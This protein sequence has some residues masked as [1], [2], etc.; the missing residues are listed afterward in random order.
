MGAITDPN[1]VLMTAILSMDIYERDP[2]YGS[3]VIQSKLPSGV[4]GSATLIESSYNRGTEFGATAWSWK[5]QAIIAYEGTISSGILTSAWNGYG[6]GAG[7]P[8]GPDAT[9]AVDFYQAVANDVDPSAYNNYQSANIVLTGHSLGG[10]L[11]GY[12]GAIYGQQGVLFDSMPF[13][14]AAQSAYI[15]SIGIVEDEGQTYTDTILRSEIYG[16]V[17]PYPNNAS[18]L[19]GY[20]VTGN[21]LGFGNAIDPHGQATAINLHSSALLVAL[22][23]ARDNGKSDW[24]SIGTPLL[25][26]LFGNQATR[27]TAALGLGTDKSVLLAEIAYSALSQV[28]PGGAL[29]FGSTALSSLFS[30][31]DTLG[32]LVS[33]GQ[34]TG[35]MAIG[36]ANSTVDNALAEIAVQYAGDQAWTAGQNGGSDGQA[37]GSGAFSVSDSALSINL[38]PPNWVSTFKAEPASSTTPNI[39]G[40]GDLV[41]SLFTSIADPLD[42]SDPVRAWIQ[43]IVNGNAAF[44]TR[45]DEITLVE[46]SLGAG[47][48]SGDISGKSATKANDGNAGGALLIG[49]S[50]QGSIEGSAQGNDI[51]IDGKTV[52]TGSGNDII[53]AGSGQVQLN[54]NGGN[55]IIYAGASSLSASITYTLNNDALM[56]VNMPSS[57]AVGANVTGA[58][59]GADLIIGNADGGDTFNFTNANHAAFT[60]AWGG[61][62]ADTFN[63]NVLPPTVATGSVVQY[64]DVPESV[65]D[66]IG[67][68]MSGVTAQNIGDLNLQ[69]LETYVDKTYS[70]ASAQSVVVLLNPS[71]GDNIAYSGANNSFSDISNGT[72]DFWNPVLQRNTEQW[73]QNN[74][75]IAVGPGSLT[76]P[77]PFITSID[78]NNFLNSGAGGSGSGGGGSGSGGSSG[79]PSVATFLADQASL[80]F[81]GEPISITDTAAAVSA[82]F[83]TLS[84]DSNVTSITLTDSGVPTLTLT[85]SQVAKDTTA[86]GEITNTSYAISVVDSAAD[87]AE[88]FDALNANTQVTSIALTDS[89]QSTLSLDAEQA[90][91]DTHALAALGAANFTIAVTDSAADVSQTLDALNADAEVSSIT[92]IDSGTPTL[93]LS[94][95][96]A[97]GDTTALAEITN[98]SYAVQI[99][100]T[101][102]NVLASASAIAAAAA[103]SSVI[104]SDT[105]ANVLA[106]AAALAAMPLV[107]AIDIVDTAANVLDNLAA[108]KATPLVSSIEVVDTAANMLASEGALAAAGIG[109]AIVLDSAANVSAVFDGLNADSS[110][111]AIALT[112]SGTPT[113]TLTVAQALNATTALGEIENPNYQ[114]AIVDTAANISANLDTLQNDAQIVSIT[115]SDASSPT[116]TLI[117]A[118]L[119]DDTTA[120]GEITNSNVTVAIVDTGANVAA[121]FDLLNAA[122]FVSSIALSDSGTPTL[123]LT[124]AQAVGDTAALQKIANSNYAVDVVDTAANVSAAFAELATDGNLASITLTDTQPVVDLTTAEALQAGAALAKV[125]NAGVQIA[126]YDTLANDLA[127]KTALAADPSVVS[128]AVVD[129]AANMLAGAQQ[130]AADAE[131][132]P[133]YVADSAANVSVN[134]NTL[135]SLRDLAGVILTDSGTPTL[136]LT[137]AQFLDDGA[138]LRKIENQSHAIDIVDTAANVSAAIDTI[139][140]FSAITSIT[141]T[142]AGTPTLALNA[143]QA[144]AGTAALSSVK[145]QSYAIVVSDSAVSVAEEA[146]ALA[147]NSHIT[148]IDV[149]DDAANVSANIDALNSL[150]ALQEISVTD[151]ASAPLTLTVAQTLDDGAALA[152][153]AGSYIIAVTDTAEAVLGSINALDA[154]PA[155][156]SLNIVDNASDVVA[157][158]VALAALSNLGTVT[159][160]DTAAAVGADASAIASDSKIT[161]VN[162]TDT[163]ANVLAN[164]TALQSLTNL[165]TV[166]VLDTTADISAN[167]GALLSDDW[168]TSIVPT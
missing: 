57:I 134:F 73:I 84:D 147:A 42:L 159:I 35:L 13:A 86:L 2:A 62:G 64:G 75:T 166:T 36:G 113:L 17:A 78:I 48:D 126:V 164:A 122:S 119:V 67:L 100:D 43:N 121:D 80:D 28:P 4:L 149:T 46:A 132:G 118:Q 101:A 79:D 140:S 22:L 34:L 76:P 120:L 71:A 129:T 37:N 32:N 14:A 18:G 6:V 108:L 162:V 137:V 94:V 25:N 61:A 90:I 105:A 47:G 93:D 163:A 130:M 70:V 59:P 38:N 109:Q 114:V 151:A 102:A 88:N 135:A 124:A 87:V 92:L 66:V 154:V 99:V 116:L 128:V 98:P 44:T 55:D 127:N 49:Q 115:A 110:V 89:G 83:D 117:V 65:V 145:N 112:D 167:I 141:L 107:S 30:D 165:G 7:V 39:I 158:Y 21:P 111:G 24:W 54:L 106:D 81:L 20:Y 161:Q 51:I 31:A 160:D 95:A 19:A 96:S 146:S 74:I 143:A 72:L 136:T 29:P 3:S 5:G 52:T 155:V 138:A 56:P 26:A 131:I 12:V 16:D 85:A 40:L 144:A 60:V 9:R 1:T 77:S 50:G 168:I 82:A 97:L 156:T 15:D 27:I 58:A 68:S 69:A 142:D 8:G 157:N 153:I 11:A 33:N 41:N 103:V 104:V 148:A 45:L 10:G 152:N 133:V 53:V 150:S 23:W 91:G 125:T 63:F 123:T 139:N